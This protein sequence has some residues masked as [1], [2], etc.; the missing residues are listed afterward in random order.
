[1]QGMDRK[2]P[3]AFLNS[4]LKADFGKQASQ[5]I[6]T[7][8][9]LPQFLGTTDLVDKVIA[10]NEGFFKAGGTYVQYNI[11]DNEILRKAQRKPEEYKDLM[12]RV[13][14]Y[15]AYFI[16]LSHEIQEELISRTE[17]TLA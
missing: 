6:L 4:A 1:M 3:T 9:I 5:A 11:V 7:L 15:S 13:G 16:N 8:K 10:L 17:H 12:V 14:G 2:G